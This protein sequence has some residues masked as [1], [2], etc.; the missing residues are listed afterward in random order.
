MEVTIGEID[1]KLQ[2]EIFDSEKDPI[3]K[4][5][6]DILKRYINI[7][8]NASLQLV[9][10]PFEEKKSLSFYKQERI[11]KSLRRLSDYIGY[12][13]KELEKDKIIEFCSRNTFI[14]TNYDIDLTV[15]ISNSYYGAIKYDLYWIQ[16]LKYFDALA[17]ST[18]QFKIERLSEY[19]PQSLEN[20]RNE[21]IPFFKKDKIFNEFYPILL[22]LNSTLKIESFRASNL[23]ILTVV[24][25]L[26]RHLGIYL[27]EKQ[28][29][30]FDP[31]DKKYNSLDSF[32]RKIEWKKDFEISMNTY[33]LINNDFDYKKKVD[34]LK[35]DVKI[36]LK[37]RLD[38]LRRRF[39]EDRDTILHGLENNYG[40]KWNVFINISALEHVY[41]T[42]V[43]Y[44]DLYK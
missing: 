14:V 2:N 10:L 44:R 33:K 4:E 11:K 32:L 9:E 19:L 15:I 23:L 35:D 41:D 38:F 26:V 31:D 36:D 8:F 39:K 12:L 42:I 24:E 16:S 43:Y 20:L 27:K 7:C 30:E 13:T 28:N 18:N 25:G 21:I 29:L 6:E 3:Y 37:E 34:P 17:I 22:E 5:R 1:R 40:E